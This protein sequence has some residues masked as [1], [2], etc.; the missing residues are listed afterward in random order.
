[1]VRVVV[2]VV[3]VKVPVFGGR[4]NQKLAFFT[5]EQANRQLLPAHCAQ[6]VC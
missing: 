3:V 4:A 6:S 1:M 2:V 5:S